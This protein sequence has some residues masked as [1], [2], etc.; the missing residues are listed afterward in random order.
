MN[1]GRKSSGSGSWRFLLLL[2][3]VIAFAIVQYWLTMP[4]ASQTS[5]LDLAVESLNAGQID[6]AGILLLRLHRESP[7]DQNISILLATVYGLQQET[8]SALKILEGIDGFEQDPA[9]LVNAAQIAMKGHLVHKAVSLMQQSLDLNPD[10]PE[11]WRLLANLHST[12]LNTNKARQS[13]IEIDRRRQLTAEDVLVCSMADRARYDIEENVRQFRESL[14]AEPGSPELIAGLAENYLTLNDIAAATTLLR[15]ADRNRNHLDDWLLDAASAAVACHVNDYSGAAEILAQLPEPAEQRQ[16]VWLLKGKVLEQLGNNTAAEVCFL[17][18]IALDPLDPDPPYLLARI[19]ESRPNGGNPEQVRSLRDRARKLQTLSIQMGALLSLKSPADAAERLVG[20]AEML[21][22]VNATREAA[23]ILAW[24]QKEDYSFRTIDAQLARL[25]TMPSAVPEVL[26]ALPVEPVLP[27]A[28][29]EFR[30]PKSQSDARV[31]AAESNELPTPRFTDVSES[32]GVSFEYACP[33]SSRTEILES[34]GGG[35]ACFD[36]DHDD[37]VDLY[38]PQGGPSPEAQDRSEDIDRCY[39]MRNGRFRDITAVAGFGSSDYGHGTAVSDFN[40]DGFDDLLVT[41]FGINQLWISQGDGTLRPAGPDSIEFPYEWSSSAVFVDLD[42]DADDDLY[43]VHYLDRLC[44][45]VRTTECAPLDLNARQ[46]RLY[47]NT[48]AGAFIDRTDTSGIRMEGGKGLGVVA[49]DF[50]RDG[51]PDLFVGNDS[52]ANFLWQNHSSAQGIR[53]TEV[54]HS[55][56]VALGSNGQ[57]QACMGVAIADVDQNGFPDLFVSNFEFESNTYYANLG[58]PGFADE[59]R[60]RGLEAGS[61]ALMGWGAQFLDVDDDVRPDLVLLNG[62][63]DA[64]PLKPQ[65]YL[66]GSNGFADVSTSAGSFFRQP[67]AGRSLGTVD[68]NRNGVPDLIATM[69]SGTPAILES[70]RSGDQTFA[71]SLRGTVCSNA[72]TGV[73]VSVRFAGRNMTRELYGGGGYLCANQQLIYLRCG[74]DRM[75]EYLQIQWPDGRKDEWN[76]VHVGSRVAA[77]ESSSASPAR[78]LTLP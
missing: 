1:S 23:A 53:L 2:A 20:V 5:D 26:L 65:V 19:V 10:Q 40:N 7:S 15:G 18:A 57:P 6:Q 77:V 64:R 13:F 14:I 24:L 36:L 31:S 78:L 51:R 41:N 9:L 63:L 54:A 67:H 69:R 33:E 72:A 29:A 16:R 17:N 30:R 60:I 76:N 58:P 42:G 47:E 27:V 61:Y 75:V 73:L 46:D 4:Q 28:A 22:D 70:T 37:H 11:T 71:L 35:V 48:G 21:L 49:S 68:L 66:Q 12:L 43:V 8:P 55:R 25:R 32:L 38:F 39:R 50:D 56:G 62:F 44:P 59:S 3:P 52:T 45:E 74:P 34:L